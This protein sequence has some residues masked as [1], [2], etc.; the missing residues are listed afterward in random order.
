MSQES[1]ETKTE[2]TAA[3]PSAKKEKATTSS[4]K[5]IDFAKKYS[6]KEVILSGRTN[7][8]SFGSIF[9]LS[10]IPDEDGNLSSI[11]KV[12]PENAVPTLYESIHKAIESGI[13]LLTSD[14]SE[15]Q[16]KAITTVPVVETNS[17]AMVEELV[18]YDELLS[19]EISGLKVALEA[20]KKEGKKGSDF[21]RNLLAEEKSGP[22]RED[23]IELIEKYI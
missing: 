2:A 16:I 6:G 13:I 9:S 7:L 22:A 5:K 3:E 1:K 14:L 18:V 19:K 11:R 20:I 15:E 12:V 21:F 17:P 23:Y 4:E 8:W 10:A